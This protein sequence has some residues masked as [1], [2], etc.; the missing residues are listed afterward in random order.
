M[1]GSFDWEG[2]VGN[3]W[4]DEWRR[5]DRS[6]AAVDEALFARVANLAPPPSHILDVGCGA[7]GTSLVLATRFASARVLGL[8][9][10]VALLETARERD[11]LHRC[12]FLQGD[13]SSWNGVRDFDL[14]ISRHGVMF[15]D[16]PVSAFV[17]LRTLAKPGAPLIFSC[18][19]SP[20]ENSWS[21]LVPGLPPSDPQ[22][23]GP[24]AFAEKARVAAIL[25]E[26]GWAGANVV[27][28]DYP[29]V[30]GA[31]EDPVADAVSFFRRIGPA[32]R[33][34]AGMDEAA[35]APALA[36]LRDGCEK[37]FDGAQVTFPAAAWIWEARA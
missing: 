9:L 6:F 14:L 21:A 36:T 5:T 24:F 18:F 3:V 16:D 28:L 8:D 13:A 4:A 12:T 27:A 22:A 29:Y 15:F 35:R 33:T 7:G 25:A 11:P 30:A 2:A 10:S 17:H 19:R 1:T 26:A 23:P 34:L 31:G 20:A 32:A 37:N